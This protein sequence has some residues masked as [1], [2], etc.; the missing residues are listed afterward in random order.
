MPLKIIEPRKGK[1]PNLSIRGTYL[2]VYVDK[3]C[4]SDR[5]S[6]ART[7]LA[8]LREKIERREY[9]APAP[10]PAAS[11][12]PTFLSAAVAYME[13]GGR[14]KYLA[15]LIKHFGEAP[16]PLEQDAI[17][18]AAMRLYPN[19]S[20][21]TRNVYVYTP[22]SAVMH[23]AGLKVVV[24]RPKGAL[25]R[26]VTDYLIPEDASGIIRCA[27]GFDREF[28]LYLKF[29][30]YTGCRMGEALDL[31]PDRLQPLERLAYVRRS[32]NGKPRTLLLREDLCLELER[33][34]CPVEGRVFRFKN[35][36][37][38]HYKLIRAKL[39]YLGLAC[40]QRRPVGWVEPVNRL[41]FVNFHTFRHT[42]ATWMRRYGGADLQGLVGTGNWSSPR[43][44]QRYAHVVARDE[45][46]RVDRLPGIQ[47]KII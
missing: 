27:E 3:S 4:G 19:V 13:T 12:G 21:A 6:V 15:A 23:H 25:G 18:A 16:L 46:S 47:K 9:P 26:T 45:W 5:R 37:N 28:A 17:D 34:Q 1:T 7:M 32:K 8:E 35:G 31:T 20:P 41:G 38:L 11:H 29:L 22:I 44:A 43:S 14:P 39:G 24:R 33:H 36:G 42:W 40:P 10:V 2:G 30:L